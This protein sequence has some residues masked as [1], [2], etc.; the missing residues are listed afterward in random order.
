MVGFNVVSDGN[1]SVNLARHDGAAPL[2]LAARNGHD[3][4]VKFLYEH[5]AELDNQCEKGINALINAASNGR[6]STV[7]RPINVD[8]EQ[9]AIR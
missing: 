1:A 6:T 9:P 5:R 2:A 7:A 8:A 4:V 3:S